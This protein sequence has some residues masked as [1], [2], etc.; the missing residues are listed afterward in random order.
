MNLNGFKNSYSELVEHP[1][2]YLKYFIMLMLRALACASIKFK[3]LKASRCCQFSL[4]GQ[5]SNP[6]PWARRPLWPPSSTASTSSR[7]F[8]GSEHSSRPGRS[9][10]VWPDP[11]SSRPRPAADLTVDLHWK[12]GEEQ[13]M[14]HWREIRDLTSAI[15]NDA[16]WVASISI[17]YWQTGTIHQI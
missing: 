8:R 10:P 17:S 11:V 1:A 14:R 15:G 2:T 9:K 4:R 5:G 3:A 16:A 7:W 13:Q 6:L 12:P